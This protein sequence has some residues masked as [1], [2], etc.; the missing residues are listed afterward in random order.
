MKLFKKF[1]ATAKYYI[2]YL[3]QAAAEHHLLLLASGLSFSVLTC[4]IPLVLILFAIL[5]MILNEP[6]IEREVSTYVDRIIPYPE[7]AAFVK[8]LIIERAEDFKIF[9]NLAGIAGALGLAFMSSGLFGSLRT[10]L[11]RVYR[12]RRTKPVWS[13]KLKDLGL[14]LLVL[15][16]FFISITI[17]P[18]SGAALEYA[19][20]LGILSFLQN[21]VM[22][23]AL[24]SMFSFLLA[25]LSFFVIYWLIPQQSL[26]KKVILYSAL[27]AAV[28]WLLAN[29][30]FG[31]Y[32]GRIMTLKNIYGAYSLIVVVAVWIYYTSFV[33]ICG[34]IIG[35]ACREKL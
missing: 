18:T 34:A 19:G 7:E 23:G 3:N 2:N 10:I 30:L 26:P 14:L 12:V 25:C 5:G 27:V 13:G 6:Q 17:L 21:E 16:Y 9:R 29:Q 28:L 15:V 22:A 32:L 11:N 35:Q 24:A 1:A 20:R 4:I 8:A 33:F 31:L